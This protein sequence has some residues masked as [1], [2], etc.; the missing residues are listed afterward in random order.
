MVSS[1]DNFLAGVEFNAS[2][3]KGVPLYDAITLDLIAYDAMAIGNHEFDFGP[4]VLADFILGITSSRTPFLSAN[5]DVSQEARLQALKAR[6]RIAHSVVVN[7]AG[8]RIGIVGTTIPRLPY[9]SS[10][11][12][13]KVNPDVAGAIQ[14]EVDPL[15]DKEAARLFSSPTC[16]APT[17]TWSW[18]RCWVVWTSWW[19]GRRRAHRHR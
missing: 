8:E 1:G 7:E 18:P 11:R 2:L 16:K 10:L 19:P 15:A 13:V 4:D 17:K 6:K 3:E 14:A 5:L 12:I 9:I